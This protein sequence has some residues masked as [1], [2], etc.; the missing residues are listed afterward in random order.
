ERDISHSSAERIIIAD[1]TTLLDYMLN[2]YAHTLDQLVVHESQMMRNI[3][4]T[5]GVVFAQSVLHQLIDQGLV[6]EAA[7][8]IVQSLAH[9][10]LN[11]RTSFKELLL[12]DKDI[13]EYLDKDQIEACFD[14]KKHLKYI[15]DIYQKVF[16]VDISL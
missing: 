13:N 11:E 6:R 15:P 4:L 3:D 14:I 16:G 2:R 7:Y 12:G 5:Q 10:A 1:A 8:N 9:K